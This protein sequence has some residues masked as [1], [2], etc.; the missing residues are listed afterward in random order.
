VV[1]GKPVGWDGFVVSH[2]CHLGIGVAEC[3]RTEW[4]RVGPAPCLHGINYDYTE[5]DSGVWMMRRD[6]YDRVGGFDERLA[7]WGHAQTEFQHRV[8]LAGVEF[9]R[10][11]QVLFWHP[12]HGGAKDMEQANRQLSAV[13]TDLRLMWS[14]Y[15]GVSPYGN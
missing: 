1:A 11:P 12:G 2:G 9:V 6:T 13:G 14:R 7:A 3:E 15:H 10:I 4:R 8:H 5:I